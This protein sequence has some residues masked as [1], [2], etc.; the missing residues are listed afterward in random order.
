MKTS[1]DHLEGARIGL[2]TFLVTT[3]ALYVFYPPNVGLVAQQ[4]SPQ[5]QN[6][7]VDNQIGDLLNEETMPKTT[8]DENALLRFAPRSRDRLHVG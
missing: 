2:A 1:L 7:E 4:E 3:L 8:A 6:E 5:N